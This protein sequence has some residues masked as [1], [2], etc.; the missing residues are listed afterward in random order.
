MKTISV[1]VYL[2]VMAR[3]A[4]A[5][6]LQIEQ[7]HES[8]KEG[9]RAREIAGNPVP[10][11]EM[12]APVPP[13]T[14]V[15]MA[16]PP[17]SRFSCGSTH[18]YQRRGAGQ[19]VDLTEFPELKDVANITMTSGAEVMWWET[20]PLLR[21][22]G[23]GMVESVHKEIGARWSLIVATD[24]RW[25]D[26]PQARPRC[27]AIHCLSDA[28]PPTGGRAMMEERRTLGEWMDT[29]LAVR[30]REEARTPI[31]HAWHMDSRRPA[32]T[33]KRARELS[34][35]TQSAP[36]IVRRE[37]PAAP[38]VLSGRTFCWD[39]EPHG[40]GRW[41]TA[42]EFAALTCAPPEWA[43]RL[44][45]SN[46]RKPTWATKM[47]SKGVVGDVAQRVCE[48]YVIPALQGCAQTWEDGVSIEEVAK[49]V[50]LVNQLDRKSVV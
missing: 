2:G 17:C 12:D 23:V 39:D 9:I 31:V 16:N 14:R 50:Y 3:G 10:V 43:R 33:C 18:A 34:S 7:S 29:E 26:V 35:F 46:P 5:A 20:G 19:L 38:C 4:E 24:P 15:V 32:D 6:G 36:R 28:P 27:H 1:H 49:N 22:K 30:W 41:W 8:W 37:D 13:R 48:D 47:L 44:V 40:P 11:V 21:V 42:E 25:A 45:E